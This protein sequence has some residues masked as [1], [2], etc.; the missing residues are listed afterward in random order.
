LINALKSSG[1]YWPIRICLQDT[2]HHKNDEQKYVL[3]YLIGAAFSLWRAVFL[4]DT[5]RDDLSVHGTQ[6]QFLK[7]VIT[8]NAIGPTICRWADGI[9][10]MNREIRLHRTAWWA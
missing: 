9:F 7:T 2:G 1:L 3:G 8:D 10:A 5:F 4:A 6:E